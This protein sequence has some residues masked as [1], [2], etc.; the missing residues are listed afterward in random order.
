M[1]CLA[2][3]KFVVSQ[4]KLFIHIPIK[5]EKFVRDNPMTANVHFTFSEISGFRKKIYFFIIR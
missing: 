1:K 5:N 3:S 2:S 4:T